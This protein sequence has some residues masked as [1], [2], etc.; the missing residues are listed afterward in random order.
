[1]QLFKRA[2]QAE[3]TARAEALGGSKLAGAS[4]KTRKEAS[5]AGAEYR[6]SSDMQV[7]FQTTIIKEV[8]QQSQSEI[9]LSVA[10]LPSFVKNAIPV[11]CNKWSAIKQSVPVINTIW[12]EARELKRDLITYHFTGHCNENP[13]SNMTWPSSKKDHPVILGIDYREGRSEL[14]R[15]FGKL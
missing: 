15:P 12:G 2:N 5:V 11:K 4:L 9:I 14:G 7:Q 6:H 8:S 1:M 13:R 3:D 10:V